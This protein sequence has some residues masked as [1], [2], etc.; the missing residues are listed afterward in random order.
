M[1]FLKQFMKRIADDENTEDESPNT[2]IDDEHW[3][4]DLPDMMEKR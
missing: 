3:V 4:L 2:I 1:N